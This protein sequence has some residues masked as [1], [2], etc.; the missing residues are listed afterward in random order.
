MDHNLIALGIYAVVLIALFVLRRQIGLF[1]S[2]TV[3]FV[4]TWAYFNYGVDPPIPNFVNILFIATTLIAVL[5]YVT[6]SKEATQDFFGPVVR[7]MVDEKLKYARIALLII[8]PAVIAWK[9]WDLAQPDDT[10]PAKVRMVHP[11][12]PSTLSGSAHGDAKGYSLDMQK[13]DNPYRALET[14]NPE[15]FKSHVTNGKRVYYQNCYYC[16]GDT[17]AADGHYANA[18][19]PIP[20]NFMDTGTIA[21]LTE[22]FVFWRIAKGGAGLPP[23][24]TPWDSSMPV[25]ENML[26]LEEMWDVTLFLYDYTGYKPRGMGGDH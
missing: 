17:L 7:V 4:I 26:S 11:P 2:T 8:I 9:A 20:A 19:I 25:W 22:T 1:I 14:S 10:P 5:L 13:D 6:S 23:G 21:M 3:F 18:L 16:H 15:A 12:P 24:S